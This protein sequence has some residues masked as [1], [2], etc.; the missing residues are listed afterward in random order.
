[1]E[2]LT[3]TDRMIEAIRKKKSVL[4]VGFDPQMNFMPPHLIRWAIERWGENISFKGKKG[5]MLTWEGVANLFLEFGKPM[6]DAVEPFC[7]SMK[8]QGAFFEC[9]GHWPVWCLEKINEY[10]K[11]KGLIVIN[12]V[13]RGDGGDTARAYA[14]GFLGEVDLFVLTE[15]DDLLQ[16]LQAPSP[17]NV[18]A[19]TIHG[20]IGS[21]CIS[22]FVEN[23]L[24][25]GK[26]T[27]VV[28]KTSFKPNSEIEQIKS[29][30]GMTVWEE[31]AFKIRKWGEATHG[32]YG[33]MN[34]GAVVGATYPK[35]AVR[36]REIL[37]RAWFLVPG[38]GRQSE[39]MSAEEAADNA[40]VSFN[41]DGLGGIVNSSGAIN[42]AWK[43]GQFSGEPEKFAEAA[44][45]AA[46]FARDE[47]DSALKRAGKLNW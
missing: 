6:I 41:D 40:V 9:Y 37:P 32:K 45:K 23:I 12:D 19:I 22:P 3:F 25:H 21:S 27:F 42:G 17:L 11:S 47:L 13:K 36:M 26:G 38:Y 1:M 7:V 29:E 30:S 20:Y 33:Y 34:L 8:P 10:T 39:G 46:E 24:K 4:N 15:D 31:M 35:E 28:D 14:N 2:N 16:T 5:K 44:A 43:K 18:D